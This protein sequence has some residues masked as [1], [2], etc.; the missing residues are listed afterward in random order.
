MIRFRRL[1]LEQ[2]R[3]FIRRQSA[4]PYTYADVGASRLGTFPSG[5]DH[6]RH[7]VLLGR[8]REAFEAA[9]DALR[10]WAM[11]PRELVEV[12]M[13]STPLEPGRVVAMRFSLFGADVWCAC[14]IVYTVDEVD[15]DVMKFGFA[16][17]TLPSHIA[18]GEGRYLIEWNRDT[19]EVCYEIASFARPVFLPARIVPF[20]MRRKQK[21]LHAASGRRMQELVRESHRLGQEL[22]K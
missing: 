10:G 15:G 12:W 6:M 11:L 17:G 8:G 21:Q 16:Y 13:P 4:L 19:D 7:R 14:R 22:L 5:Y 3:Q 2:I 20:A 9:R 1:S 18:Q